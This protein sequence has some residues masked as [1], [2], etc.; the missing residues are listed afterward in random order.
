MAQILLINPSLITASIGHYSRTVEKNRGVYPP[1]GLAYIAS[2]L[3]DAGHSVD[4]VDCD[5]DPTI[6]AKPYE[7]VG[8]YV[9]TWTYRNAVATLKTLKQQYPDIRSVLGGPHATCMPLSEDFDYVVPGEGEEAM[10][11]LIAKGSFTPKPLR[12]NLDEIS[13]PAWDLL[14]LD[15]YRDVFSRHKKFATMIASRGCPFHCTFCDR[16]NRM[17]TKW[18][19]RSVDNV[20][21]EIKLI[22][23]KEIMFYDDNFVFNKDWV[24]DFCRKVKPLKIDWECRTRVD[25][26]NLSLLK[27]MKEAGCYRIRYGMESG[28]DAVLST[29]K[30]GITV[31][32]IKDCVVDT[33]KAGIEIFAYFMMGS[34]Y[35]TKVT[36]Q[37]TLNLALWVNAEFTVL[38]KTILIVGSE[39]FDWAVKNKR[40]DPDYWDKFIKDGGNSAPALFGKEVDDFINYSY[41]KLY[42]RPKQLWALT[43]LGINNLCKLL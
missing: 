26:V 25:T 17:G 13:F 33:R 4:I 3:R 38:S 30:K 12:A 37:D 18:R 10:V 14:Q 6:P 19:V 43:K 7:W 28:N 22:G 35:E 36:L 1:L 11:E 16:K 40:I 20:I 21:E 42:L 27:A 34:P 9:M 24:Y 8:F 32:Q 31:Q 23:V 15:K 5:I 41:K 29:L 2:A 39:L